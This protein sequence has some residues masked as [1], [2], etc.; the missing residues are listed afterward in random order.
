[1]V[2]QA[3]QPRSVTIGVGCP[4]PISASDTR[5]SGRRDRFRAAPGQ[6]ELA[7]LLD[8]PSHDVASAGGVSS[9]TVIS[10]FDDSR[11]LLALQKIEAFEGSV[12]GTP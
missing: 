2:C 7:R 6:G 11:L 5:Q 9:E 12:P 4:A 10:A 3:L 8:F 1:M